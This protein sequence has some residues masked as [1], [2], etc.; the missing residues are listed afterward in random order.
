MLQW[1]VFF[2]DT[3]NIVF[4]VLSNQNIGEKRMLQSTQVA[5]RGCPGAPLGHGSC[6]G[7]ELFLKV[8]GRFSPH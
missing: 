8:Q 7:P 1:N 4:E 3:V 5:A 2:N 6:Y